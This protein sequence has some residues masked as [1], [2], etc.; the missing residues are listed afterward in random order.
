MKKQLRNNYIDN[1]KFTECLIKLRQEREANPEVTLR[2]FSESE[3]LGECI[4]AL[5][6]NLARRAN[7]V[8]Y[9]YKDDFIADAVENCLR[10]AINFDHTRSINAF[11]YFTQV[12]FNAFL[13]RIAKEKQNRERYLKMLSDSEAL[14]ELINA[15][16]DDEEEHPDAVE[17]L[18]QTQRY[19]IEHD[20]LQE[21]T[22]PRQPRVKKYPPSPFDEFLVDELSL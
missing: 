8:G 17:F 12:A 19:L 15:Q 22:P 3:Y 11:G 21:Q 14:Q 9:S 2:T 5:C 7:F 4:I 13:R 10:A 1:K 16:F 18:N 20:N 6:T